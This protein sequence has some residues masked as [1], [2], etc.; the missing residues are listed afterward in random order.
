MKPMKDKVFAYITH[1]HRRF[2][3]LR[4]TGSP[5]ETWRHEEADPSDGESGPILFEF[6]WAP[7]PDGVPSLIA[8]QGKMLPPLVEKLFSERM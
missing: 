2:Y 1:G 7:L 6:F 5:P 3:H 8:D 4:C